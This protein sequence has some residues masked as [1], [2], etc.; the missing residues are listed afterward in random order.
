M[1]E[2]HNRGEV[3]P[4]ARAPVHGAPDL[5]AGSRPESPAGGQG[6]P[7]RPFCAACWGAGYVLEVEAGPLGP[8]RVRCDACLGTRAARP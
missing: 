6:R 1:S 8:W 7:L 2:I 3:D 5:A 4:P